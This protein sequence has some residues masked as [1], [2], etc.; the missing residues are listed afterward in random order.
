M[1]PK[2]RDLS[3]RVAVGPSESF[4][5]RSHR[6]TLYRERSPPR[7]GPDRG[8]PLW[9][10]SA[11]SRYS[12]R[13]RARLRV[14]NGF[15]SGSGNRT[16][17]HSGPTEPNTSFCP[18]RRSVPSEPS[19]RSRVLCRDTSSGSSLPR[20]FSSRRDVPLCRRTSFVLTF[21]KTY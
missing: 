6:C 9:H 3:R 20:P 2:S 7:D 16:D 19:L 11:G 14:A 1:C 8:F 15:A 21:S 17:R 12:Q 18:N 5:R 4:R 10:R 13:R